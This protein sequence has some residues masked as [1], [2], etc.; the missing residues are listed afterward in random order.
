LLSRVG[1]LGPT[2][3]AAVLAD[4]WALAK[5]VAGVPQAGKRQMRHILGHLPFSDEFERISSGREKRTII[6]R[7]T[8]TPEREIRAWPD[9]QMDP[10]I[11]RTTP[12]RREP[13]RHDKD[14]FLQGRFERALAKST[15]G[16]NVAPQLES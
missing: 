1:K 2:E 8:G 16:S 6:A 12:A 9:D 14:R 3:C 10:Q 13:S 7:L 11:A 5:W 4:A 15:A